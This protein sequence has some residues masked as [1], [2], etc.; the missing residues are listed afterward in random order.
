MATPRG[1]SGR[2]STVRGSLVRGESG[3]PARSR[4]AKLPPPEPV[5]D[6]T[7]PRSVIDYALQRRS[8][9]RRFHR[10]GI[11]SSDFCDADPY[12]LKAA[13]FHGE[14]VADDCPGCH[15]PELVHLTYVYGDELGP[16]SGRIRET[17]DL[18]S[19]ATRFGDIGVY[20]VEVCPDCHWNYLLR[21][22]RIGDGVPRRALPTP[23]DDD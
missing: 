21:T 4:R 12:L 22:Y 8:D 14:P 13:T 2:P 17:K 19:L 7:A 5:E 3:T 11:L 9:I 23:R 15:S 10:G 16:Y 1:S 20:T 6:P 18:P